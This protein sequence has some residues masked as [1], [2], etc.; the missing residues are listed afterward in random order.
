MPTP[1]NPSQV[2]ANSVLRCGFNRVVPVNTSL[3]NAV[4]GELMPDSGIGEQALS[5][6]SSLDR[7]LCQDAGKL[8]TALQWGD[9]L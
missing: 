7:T 8:S 6:G 1:S 3:L 9:A 4:D 5:S 2:L